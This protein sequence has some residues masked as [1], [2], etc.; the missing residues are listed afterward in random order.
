MRTGVVR[1]PITT[2]WTDPERLRAVDKPAWHGDVRG[3]VGAMTLD[4]RSDLDGRTETQLLLGD[5][6]LVEEVRGDFALVIA[7]RQ[8]APRHFDQGYPGWVNVEHIA[9]GAPERPAPTHVVAVPSTSIVDRRHGAILA[10]DVVL[11]TEVTVAGTPADGY[12]PLDYSGPGAVGTAYIPAD[13]IVTRPTRPPSGAELIE[14]ASLLLGTPYVWGGVS[15]FGI[16]CSGLVHLTCRR[17]GITIA[18]NADDQ[19]DATT[20]L[21]FGEERPGDVYFFQ[22]PGKR[23]H[24]VGFVAA[25]PDPDG[26]RH[27]LHACGTSR[28]VVREPVSG[29]R[30]DT[31]VAVHR[32]VS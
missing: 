1:V 14:T 11:G 20:P 26:T 22:R 3:W 16:D 18:R 24:H 19:A 7:T 21:I 8:P 30:M 9:I 17:L 4:E 31:L 28:G 25:A 23:V 6:V 29:E 10:A 13:A 15:P 32:L 27:M 5:P 12:V 2:V